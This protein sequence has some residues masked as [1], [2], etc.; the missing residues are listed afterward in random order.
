[1]YLPE[2]T[3]RALNFYL[4]SLKESKQSF[5]EQFKKKQHN[6]Q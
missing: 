5:P 2:E 3:F 1:M 4:L 6:Y